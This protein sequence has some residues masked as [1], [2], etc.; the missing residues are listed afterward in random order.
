MTCWD[1]SILTTSMCYQGKE[2]TVMIEAMCDLL[3]QK[4]L[5]NQCMCYQGKE[6]TVMIEAMCD[7]LGQKH[8]DNQYVSRQRMDS[9]DTSNATLPEM[10]DLLEQKHLD[11][12]SVSCQ[13]REWTVM[14]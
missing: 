6:D 3:G 14:T 9:H 7:L 8:L 2:H 12:Q 1:K 13:G 10:C 4:Y 5:D 11:S